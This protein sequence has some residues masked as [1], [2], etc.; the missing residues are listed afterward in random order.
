MKA[1]IIEAN[2]DECNG[3]AGIF[4][5][6]NFAVD[7]CHDGQ[8][9][10][11]LGDT[12]KYD[13]VVLSLSL[14]RRDGFSVLSDWRLGG[15]DTP[16]VI[17]DTRNCWREKVRCLRAGADDV[18]TRPFELEELMARAEVALRRSH[19]H[20]KCVLK[21]GSLELDTATQRLTLKGQ[22][23]V[24]SALEYRLMAI[25]MNRSNQVVSKTTLTEYLYQADFECN[26]NVVEV[27]INRVR[28]KIGFEFIKTRRGLGYQIV[29]D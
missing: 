20:A 29:P 28:N 16:V 8:D 5:Q 27:L 13:V 21:A 14:P 10:W 24:L 7:I 6:N 26:S 1:L 23:I 3:M 15:N 17:V 18:L 2:K 22:P 19:G 9:A 11:F 4:R 12:E 25:L